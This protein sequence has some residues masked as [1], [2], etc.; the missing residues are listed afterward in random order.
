[1]CVCGERWDGM[2]SN[3]IIRLEEGTSRVPTQEDLEVCL[4]SSIEQ[5]FDESIA[6]QNGVV[7][8]R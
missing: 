6:F 8:Y 5:S 7:D 4:T 3:D 1:M 2:E